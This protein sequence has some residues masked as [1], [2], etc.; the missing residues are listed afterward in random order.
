MQNFIFDVVISS[1]HKF[2]VARR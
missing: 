2:S 1:Y